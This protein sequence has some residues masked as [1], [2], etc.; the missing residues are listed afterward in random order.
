MNYNKIIAIADKDMKMT[1]KT[2]K[3]WISLILLP[4]IL[5]V[6]IPAAIVSIGRWADILALGNGRIMLLLEH[7]S[8]PDKISMPTVNHR[9]VYFMTQYMLVPIFM[10][11]PV[12]NAMMIA[13]NSFVGE[14]ERRTLESLLFAPIEIK[15]LFIG[16]LLASFIPAYASTLASFLVGGIIMNVL[17]YPMFGSII[18]PSLNWFILLF[19]VIPVFTIS[20][21]LFSVLV[22]ARSKGFQ[23][24][25]QIAGV[26]VLPIVGLLVG[27]S[28]GVVLMSP[29]VLLVLGGA[30]MGLN[31]VL[32]VLIAKLNQRGL[33]FERQI[34]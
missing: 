7:L 22:S 18:F 26:I 16:K 34:Q 24:A 21:I 19:W 20:A 33:L 23:E 32:L 2:G 12:I 6:L 28:T 11:I 1:R 27:Q 4:L 14:K 3:V 15:D 13:V 17:A 30:L 10:L 9:F 8:I 29:L 5:G 25:Q 31:L